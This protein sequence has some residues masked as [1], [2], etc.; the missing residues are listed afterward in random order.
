MN[1]PTNTPTTATTPQVRVEFTDE[2]PKFWVFFKE[3]AFGPG[4][5][6]NRFSSRM[7]AGRFF[8]HHVRQAA[9]RVV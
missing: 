9:K 4:V 2:G 7:K 5:H 8:D 1:H 6:K 3:P